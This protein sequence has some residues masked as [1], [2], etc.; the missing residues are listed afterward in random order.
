MLMARVIRVWLGHEI[1]SQSIELILKGL[2]NPRKATRRLL[3]KF[4]RVNQFQ[5]DFVG[6]RSLRYILWLDQIYQRIETVPGHIVELGVG[7]GR[8]AVIFGNLV[9]LYGDEDVRHYY[10][11]DTFQGY[12]AEDIESSPHLDSSAWKE[13]NAGRVR[14]SLE[15]YQVDS[16][17]TLIQGDLKK[18]LPKFIRESSA[19]L[20]S[21]GNFHVAL[22]YVDCN[23]Y[24]ASLTG[25]E[26][27]YEHMPPG[28]IIC[29]DELRQ[30]G[31]TRALKKFCEETDL[32]FEK[33]DPPITWGP[34]TVVE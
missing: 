9:K 17:T 1:M 30:G 14:A 4:G 29:V 6:K 34:Y 27:L 31:E 10:G 16:L 15:D 21:P 26:T 7:P 5:T 12:T 3:R 25:M 2:A 19:G 28:A 18:T 13:L 33:A 24:L 32:P 11:F 8:N 22:L 23:S 20:K